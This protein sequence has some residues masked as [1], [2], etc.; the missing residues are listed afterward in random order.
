[1]GWTGG[2]ERGARLRTRLEEESRRVASDLLA[3]A[4][5]LGRGA[6]ADGFDEFDLAARR[7][8]EEAG[9]DEA[10]ALVRLHAHL[11]CNRLGVTPLEEVLLALL[12]VDGASARIKADDSAAAAGGQNP[13]AA[14]PDEPTSEEDDEAAD[15]VLRLRAVAKEHDSEAALHGV[16]FDVRE[17]ELFGLF[18]PR[19]AGKTSVLAVAAGLRLPSSGS[20]QALGVD[21]LEERGQLVDQVMLVA[22]DGEVAEQATVRENLELRARSHG[23][24]QTA[25]D[26]VLSEAGLAIE[27]ATQV[28]ELTPGARRLLAIACALVSA[29]RLLLVDEPGAGLSPVEREPV[30]E[31]LRSQR[32]AGR[33]VVVATTSL[34]EAQALCDRVAV[35]VNGTVLAV[36]TPAEIA[37][38]FPMRSLVFDTE[39]EPDRAALEDLPEVGS[40]RIESHAGHWTLELETHQPEELLTLI[41]NDPAF[42]AVLNRRADDD[43]AGFPEPGDW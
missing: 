24:A 17:G 25:P 4:R 9:D 38:R 31:L 3:A 21:P 18:G 13:D 32:E 23:G 5:E 8:F 33:T 6:G 36:E 1:M 40:V 27:A 35:V 29:P 26:A 20:V 22:A 14:E 11:S 42:P 2:D 43:E 37:E 15:A 41:E 34:R 12:L 16:S 28:D 19:G 10:P 30:W 7:L 39:S